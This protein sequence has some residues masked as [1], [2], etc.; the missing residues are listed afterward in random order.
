MPSP[1]LRPETRTFNSTV[2]A[3]SPSRKRSWKFNRGDQVS[4]IKRTG[5]KVQFNAGPNVA[6]SGTFEMELIS[7]ELATKQKPTPSQRE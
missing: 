5:G 2:T 4:N 7:F 3:L 6:T 1:V